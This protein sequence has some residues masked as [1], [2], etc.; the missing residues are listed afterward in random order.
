MD[1]SVLFS[2]FSTRRG[3]FECLFGNCRERQLSFD[4]CGCCCGDL[5]L[6]GEEGDIEGE[7]GVHFRVM[8]EV[9]LYASQEDDEFLFWG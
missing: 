5:G 3:V 2:G 9:H 4:G 1:L 6:A 8:E 7:D